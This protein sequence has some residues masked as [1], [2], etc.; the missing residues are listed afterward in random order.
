MARTIPDAVRELCLAFPETEET[1]SHGKPDFKVAGK[2]F[3]WF[4]INHHGDGHVALW[5]RSPEGA[6]QHFVELDQENYFVPEYLGPRGWLGVEL[7]KGIDWSEVTARVREAWE[8][9]APGPLKSELG[10]SPQVP[11]PEVAMKPE[12]INPWLDERPRGIFAELDNRCRQ[13]PEVS[14][15]KSFGSPVWKAGKKTFAC[16]H[17]GSGRLRL[18]FWVGVENQAMMTADP[19]YTIPMYIGHNGWIDLDVESHIDWDEVEGLLDRSYRH[20]AL[21]RMIKALD[22]D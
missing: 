19:R 6:Q 22:D 13:F 1:L 8:N 9:A 2:S 14:E 16:A 18:Q 17:C 5:L 21:K 3:A 7:N 10:E 15:G 20:F 4:C 11:P 12:E